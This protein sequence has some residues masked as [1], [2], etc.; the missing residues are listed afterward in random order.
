MTHDRPQTREPRDARL[1]TIE[2][3]CRK[4]GRSRAS[5]HRDV[6]AGLLPRPIKIGSS[7]RWID[8]EIDGVIELARLQR[9][10]EAER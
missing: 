4:L 5:V 8:T 6:A 2:D 10:G 9:D 7:S 1:L 3:V